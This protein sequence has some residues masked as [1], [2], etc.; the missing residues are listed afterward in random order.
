MSNKIAY[1]V[2]PT[3]VVMMIDQKTYTVNEGDERYAEVRAAIRDED[4]DLI[5]NLLDL[6]GRLITESNGGIYLMNGMLRCDKYEIPALLATRIVQMFRE[7]FSVKPLSLFLENLMSNPNESGSV[8]EELYTFIEKSNLPITADGHFLA[9]KMVKKNFTDLWTGTMDNSVGAIPELDRSTCDFN[10]DATCSRG[11]HFCSE[12]YL[13][14]YGSEGSSQV[15]IVKVNPRDVTSIPSD[16]NDEKGRACKYEIMEAIGWKDLITPLFTNE[17][18][19]DIDDDA[20]D[21]PTD[22]RWELRDSYTGALV[23]SFVTR[24]GARDARSGNAS[25]YIV[26]TETGEVVAGSP[27]V[28]P[29]E[30]EYDT[31]AEDT[32]P[33]KTNPSA[34]LNE[35]TVRE[36]R[37][38]LAKGA[39]ETLEELAL[40]FGVSA[41]T[42]GRIR[43]WKSWTHVTV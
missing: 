33:V 25:L 43:D 22:T 16:H 26:D 27:P 35:K 5:P 24:Q 20:Q 39:Y 30:V 8:V 11:L 15:V 28:D 32:T 10:R 42:I 1:T 18:S 2:T 7:G 41:R 36:I 14:S 38:I 19:E 23:N 6:K 37:N 17:H 34:V 21:T 4:F 12:G 3:A 9:Y 40:M 31:S 13:G 29:E